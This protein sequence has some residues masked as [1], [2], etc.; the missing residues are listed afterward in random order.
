M[1]KNIG[2]IKIWAV[3]IGFIALFLINFGIKTNIGYTSMM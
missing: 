3:F 2:L 1:K